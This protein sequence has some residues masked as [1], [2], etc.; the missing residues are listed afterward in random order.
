[1]SARTLVKAFTIALLTKRS[2]SL[3]ESQGQRT[4]H[5]LRCPA[6]GGRPG[7][8]TAR[9]QSS[10][11]R[12][13]VPGTV[14]AGTETT[15]RNY[16]QWDWRERCAS[17]NKRLSARQN[18]T[19]RATTTKAIICIKLPLYARPGPVFRR[20]TVPFCPTVECRMC[21]DPQPE[22]RRTADS[23]RAATFS[24]TR[25]TTNVRERRDQGR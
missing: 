22:T 25:D 23:A 6:V 18:R 24:W 21:D 16:G 4:C 10:P 14:G 1:M 5:W 15:D 7:A 9:V 20:F 13:R 2:L 11:A 12:S 17:E 8:G 3:G 19:R